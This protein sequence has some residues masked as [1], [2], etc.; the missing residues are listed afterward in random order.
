VA[1]YHHSLIAPMA[2]LTF[3]TVSTKKS[4]VAEIKKSVQVSPY[5]FPYTFPYTSTLWGLDK[6]ARHY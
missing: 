6:S 3:Y 4:K 5:T 1:L 2:H